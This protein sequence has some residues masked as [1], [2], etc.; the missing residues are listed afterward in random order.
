[1]KNIFKKIMLLAVFVLL[2]IVFVGC[3][4]NDD[5][6][7]EGQGGEDKTT[8]EVKAEDMVIDFVDSGERRTKT[9]EKINSE[10]FSA[11]AFISDLSFDWVFTFAKRQDGSKINDCF[12]YES[13][14]NGKN[15]F[16]CFSDDD[17]GE[18]AK[19][20][21]LFCLKAQKANYLNGK[22]AS[23]GYDGTMDFNEFYIDFANTRMN[24]EAKTMADMVVFYVYQILMEEYYNSI[25]DMNYFNN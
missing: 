5:N 20:Y 15:V 4:K 9:L 21:A 10:T 11:G 22:Y 14:T 17:K 13:Y 8:E 18:Y 3:G 2:A 23:Y 19:D 24:F 16:E 25:I 12:D 1:M 6:N 7:D